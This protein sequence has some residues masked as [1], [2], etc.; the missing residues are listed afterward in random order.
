MQCPLVQTEI[1]SGLSAQLIRW[2]GTAQT[3]HRFRESYLNLLFKLAILRMK[4]NSSNSHSP[5]FVHHCSLKMKSHRKRK[6][7]W[8]KNKAKE[9]FT[10]VWKILLHSLVFSRIFGFQRNG[11]LSKIYKILNEI[12]AFFSSRFW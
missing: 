12:L 1:Y 2:I 6:V 7:A 9:L 11:S 4:S 10:K 3:W 5:S 8:P